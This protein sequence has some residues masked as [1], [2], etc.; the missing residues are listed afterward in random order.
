MM[1]P[2]CVWLGT[3]ISRGSDHLCHPCE[4]RCRGCLTLGC[5]WHC[6][7][8]HTAACRNSSLVIAVNADSERTTIEGSKILDVGSC[9]FGFC[10]DYQG[11][12]WHPAFL[13]RTHQ[14]LHFLLFADATVIFTASCCSYT[15]RG[16]WVQ[17]QRKKKKSSSRSGW[18]FWR[19]KMLFFMQMLVVMKSEGKGKTEH[20]SR[21][22][23]IV[24]N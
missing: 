17:V 4:W 21:R 3:G 24:S 23:K 2:A 20:T 16:L 19:R 15:K 5:V 8:R 12:R 6:R 14:Q 10:A 13:L 22:G 7:E 11:Q 18:T 9:P 1:M